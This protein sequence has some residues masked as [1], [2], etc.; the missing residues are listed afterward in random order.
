MENVYLSG[1]IKQFRY[2]KSLGDKTFEQLTFEDMNFQYNENCNSISIIVKHMAGNMFSRWTNFL[3]EDGE[4]SWR[5]RDQEFQATFTS[6]EELLLEWE[7]GW[8]C[9]FDS[10]NPLADADLG[11][12]VHIRNEGHTIAEAIFR[13]LGHYSYHVGQIVYIAKMIKG[14]E[15]VSL[16]IPKGA[17][18]AYNQ[19]KFNQPKKRQHFTDDV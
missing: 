11:K 13:Q 14:K 15:W 8:K 5:K 1:I 12:I 17:S 9:L 16:S 18:I 19:N 6:K 7:K 2:Y 4:K 3:T 10:I